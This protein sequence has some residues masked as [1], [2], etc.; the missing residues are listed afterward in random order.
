MILN[1]FEGAFLPW[2]ER[3][4]LLARAAAELDAIA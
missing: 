2:P 1:G 4:D 3:R